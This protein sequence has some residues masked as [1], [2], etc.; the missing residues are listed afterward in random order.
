MNLLS[1]AAQSETWP[2]IKPLLTK[3]KV[4]RAS[5]KKKKKKKK[6]SRWQGTKD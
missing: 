4:R 2:K 5:A 1:D 6:K 3:G